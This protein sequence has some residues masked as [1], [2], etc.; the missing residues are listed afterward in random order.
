MYK[1]KEG[2]KL[3]DS[4]D[5]LSR[6][7]RRTYGDFAVSPLHEPD[8]DQD[9]EHFHVVYRHPNTVNIDYVRRYLKE[10]G[11]HVYNDF[12]LGLHHPRNYQRYLL[13]LDN[14]EKQQFFS[15]EIAIVNNFPLD[16][17][18]DLSETERYE[19]QMEIEAFCEEYQIFEYATMCRFL[20]EQS[21]F[22]HYRYFTSHTHHFSKF[23]DS[24]RNM[25]RSAKQELPTIE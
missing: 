23:L 15:N 20:R 22:D 5:D 1:D 8:E 25:N 24:L 16:L 14:P 4:Q 18:K 3:Y 10:S 12:V 2:V 21:K 13:H 17:S 6:E 9:F 19:M 7:L 11:V